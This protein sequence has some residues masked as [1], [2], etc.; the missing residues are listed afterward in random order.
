MLILWL[1]A[2]SIIKIVLQYAIKS[3]TSAIMVTRNHPSGNKEPSETDRTVNVGI[4][5][6][7]CWMVLVLLDHLILTPDKEFYSIADDGII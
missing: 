7:S 3:N 2:Y 6:A 1:L 5:A 4:K